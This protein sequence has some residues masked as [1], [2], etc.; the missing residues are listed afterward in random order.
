MKK[1]KEDQQ[2]LVDKWSGIKAFEQIE[3]PHL[4]LAAAQVLMNQRNEASEI[5]E[6]PEHLWNKMKYPLLIRLFKQFECGKHEWMVADTNWPE[7]ANLVGLRDDNRAIV[8]E[9]GQDTVW[10][11]DVVEKELKTKWHCE[12]L[13]DLRAVN[14]MDPMHELAS[15][16]ALE[17]AMEIVSEV[18]RDLEKLY[19]KNNIL[20]YNYCLHSFR[21]GETALDYESFCPRTPILMRYIKT[22]T[23]GD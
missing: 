9:D 16:M 14:G 7:N 18:K 5:A 15:I 4:R 19:C 11:L 1:I 6:D 20:Q 22:A 23:F 12:A 13:Q 8:L 17:I 2:N 21:L 3:T 10:T